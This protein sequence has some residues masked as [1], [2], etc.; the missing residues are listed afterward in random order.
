MDAINFTKKHS[1]DLN[2]ADEYA[3]INSRSITHKVFEHI[4][5]PEEGSNILFIGCGDGRGIEEF[6]KAFGSNYN[7]TAI[8]F[9]PD[10]V[11]KTNELFQE[12]NN[13]ILDA[14]E[15][16]ASDLPFD[17]KS[18]DLALSISVLHWLDK[19]G[20]KK[21]I[22]ESSRV[23]KEDGQMV[24]EHAVSS[25]NKLIE[26][27]GEVTGK[28]HEVTEN[29]PWTKSGHSKWAGWLNDT[30]IKGTTQPV[31]RLQPLPTEQDKRNWF[32]LF[33]TSWKEGMELNKEQ[34]S[35]IV[36][37]M[38]TDNPDGII[39]NRVTMVG[40]KTPEISTFASKE[41]AGTISPRSVIEERNSQIAI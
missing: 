35:E 28:P 2:T 12:K 24:F 15:A 11:K 26:I 10:M 18:I 5:K 16:S 19:K 1:N 31:E 30:S 41:K 9:D 33:G 29:D 14:R 39:Y 22:N 23:L 4:K 36:R 32:D 38:H 3:K 7:F 25:P 21:A 34:V 13:I 17:D 8:D 27:L 37:K 20:Q 6:I 40:T